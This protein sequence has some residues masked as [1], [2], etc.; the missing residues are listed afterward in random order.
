VAAI[1][2]A[3]LAASCGR[4][5]ARVA[6]GDALAILE[7]TPWLDRLPE[8]EADV[9]H[10]YVFA[11]G[12]G[13]FVAGNAYKGSYEVFR[14]VAEGDRLRLRFTDEGRTYDARFRIERAH[15]PVFDWKLTLE[16]A[17]RGP[18]VCYG[19]QHG[20]E[21]DRVAPRAARWIRAAR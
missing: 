6:D 10:T 12:E 8:R 18:E 3:A 13:V 15:H 9:F 11:R 14:Y 4:D 2:C 20:H 21:L 1:T 16:A 7:S 19:V 17:P 5:D